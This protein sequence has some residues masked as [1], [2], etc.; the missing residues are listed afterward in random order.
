MRKCLFVLALGGMLTLGICGVAQAQDSPQPDPSQGQGGHGRRGMNPDRQLERLTRAL[1]LTSDQQSQIKPLLADRDQKM[2][3][4]FQDQTMSQD[5]RRSQSKAIR[6]DTDSKIMAI[7]ND[8][9]KQQYTAM[10][11]RMRHRGGQG[12]PQE[13]S[14][15]PQ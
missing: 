2:Q 3:A 8:D 11:E 10:Q 15:P 7:L 6:D 12:Q 4:L 13:S 1:N 9:Q 5:D 14:P